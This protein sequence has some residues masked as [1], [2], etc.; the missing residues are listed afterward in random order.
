MARKAKKETSWQQKANQQSQLWLGKARTFRP[1]GRV[2][3]ILFWVLVSLTGAIILL[4][5]LYPQDRGLPFARVADQSLFWAQHDDM[6]QAITEQFDQTRLRLAVGKDKSVEFL[7]KSAGAEPN[8]ELMIDEL[9]GYPLWQ[10]F[11]PGSLLWQS[12][13]MTQANVYY[14]GVPFQKFIQAKSKELSFSPQ[15]ARLAIEDGQLKATEAVKGSKVNS[16]QLLQA[17]SRSDVLLGKTTTI[18]A[19]SNRT[20]AARTS[21]DLSKVYDQAK[22]ALAHKIV[23]TA[24]DDAFT[25]DEKEIASW[26][27][28]ATTDQ[29]DVTLSVDKSKIQA[30]L[31]DVNTKVG[32][33]AGQTN[34]N[35]V[36]GR[37]V[38]RTTG[39]PGRAIDVAS[40]SEQIASSLL[41][42]PS[43]VA[44][45][46]QFVDVQPSVIF[47]SKYTATQAGLQA[48]INDVARSRNM[49]IS[50]QQLDGG[51]WSA[52]AREHESIPS[53]ST[54]KLFV[55]LVLFDRIEKGE[56][57][58]ED[59]MMDTTVAGCFDRMTVA[60]TN[61][62]AESW[63]AQFGR[64]YIND[65][66][67]ARGFSSGTSFTT[68]SANQTTAA[69]LTRYMI[70]LNDGTLVGGANRD[71]L[72]NNL[73]RHPYRYGI[74][75]GSQ[76]RVNDKVGF[77]W[78][79][80]HDTA[81]VHHPR[82]TYIMTI[83]TKGQ[84]YGAIASVTREIERIMY[85]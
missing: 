58:W 68:G 55:A 78:D 17:I 60:S 2:R 65:F 71:R 56:I 47:N 52:G 51:M 16:D 20:P 43:E 82:G 5:L 42:P 59:P 77:L 74:P 85:P 67:Y 48:Y 63:I 32:T 6:A 23:I 10:R 76:G 49:R 36:D 38:G 66:V 7:I 81:I 3:R 34:I 45:V 64:Q 21:R 22:A 12:G 19:P 9:R 26:V 8:T 35:I 39:S 44:V 18:E 13:Q 79:Y 33:P 70:G 4:Q 53:G 14:S 62:C 50:I 41:T 11:I 57:H 46:A 72:L 84:S 29:G 69:D 80:I 73:G 83:M 27:V 54:Y 30:Y 28:L 15:N 31:N 37:E 25:P 24:D 40:L 61:P 75:T 1:S